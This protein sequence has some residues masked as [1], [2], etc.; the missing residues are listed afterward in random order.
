MSFE[1]DTDDL[2]VALT[3]LADCIDSLQ[4]SMWRLGLSRADL[5]AAMDEQPQV[6]ESLAR[7]ETNANTLIERAASYQGAL[8]EI[9]RLYVVTEDEV[10][11]GAQRVALG[12]GAL[13]S[14][15]ESGADSQVEVQEPQTRG[16]ADSQGPRFFGGAREGPLALAA[17]LFAATTRPLG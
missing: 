11:D 13:G 8:E 5:M 7:A 17:E 14:A 4:R 12:G 15:W 6:V 10:L 1:I 3:G 9:L 2:R 16:R